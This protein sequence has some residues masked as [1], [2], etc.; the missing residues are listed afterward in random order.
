M[1]TKMRSMIVELRVAIG[2]IGLLMLLTVLI[3]RFLS[4]WREYWK[5]G[6]KEF[7]GYGSH[8][9]R[10]LAP[11]LLGT[12]KADFQSARPGLEVLRSGLWPI[13]LIFERPRHKPAYAAFCAAR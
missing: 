4:R 11:E 7:S 3:A 6:S 10:E 5:L 9:A 13:H 2:V 12:K 1:T 8:K